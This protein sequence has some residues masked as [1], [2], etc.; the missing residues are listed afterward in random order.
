MAVVHFFAFSVFH[1]KADIEPRTYSVG[2][3]LTLFHSGYSL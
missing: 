1:R 3:V 2:D